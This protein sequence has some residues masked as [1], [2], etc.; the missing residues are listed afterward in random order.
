MTTSVVDICNS[1][2]IHLGADRISSLSDNSDEARACNQFYDGAR[3]AVLPQAHWTFA[4]TQAEL[5]KLTST[6]L[7]KYAYAYQLPTDPYCLKPLFME[8]PEQDTPWKVRGRELHTDRDGVKI[9]YIWRQD[10][11]STYSP[12]FVTCLEYFLAAKC[13]YAVTGSNTK[14]KEMMEMYDYF[15]ADAEGSDAQ[16]GTADDFESDDLILTRR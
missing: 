3:D 14:A 12:L 10:D 11:V 2:L 9:E 1:A 6:P 4:T 8:N 5:S 16:V 13:A 15:L 7:F